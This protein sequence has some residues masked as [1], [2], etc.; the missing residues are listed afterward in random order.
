LNV[1]NGPTRVSLDGTLRDPVA[2]QGAD[3]R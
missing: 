1:A 3:V 2:F